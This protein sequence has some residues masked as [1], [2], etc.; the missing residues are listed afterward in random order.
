MPVYVVY[1]IFAPTTQSN[2]ELAL[3]CWALAENLSLIY[4]ISLAIHA[5]ASAAVNSGGGLLI[6]RL[7][8]NKY[9]D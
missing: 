9:A 8:H 2:S 1:A 3:A 5:Q 7:I 6:V 4:S